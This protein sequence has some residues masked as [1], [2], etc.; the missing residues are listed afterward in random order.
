MSSRGADHLNPLSV[1][2]LRRI[3]VRIR[4]VRSAKLFV[5][6]GVI[7]CVTLRTGEVFD[8]STAGFTVMTAAVLSQDQAPP[9][10]AGEFEKLFGER[11][12]LV[13]IRQKVAKRSICHRISLFHYS[14]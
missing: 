1:R 6:M 10:V 14:K 9:Q 8:A 7:V 12:R 13:K 3:V 11:H 4:H 5:R 2:G